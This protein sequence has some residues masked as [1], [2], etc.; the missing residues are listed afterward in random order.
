MSLVIEKS[1]FLSTIIYLVKIVMLTSLQTDTIN[2]SICI[3]TDNPIGQNLGR[4]QL[5]G[6]P[7]KICRANIPHGI[8]FA[9]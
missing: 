4:S 5:C 9:I 7:T 6:T 1:F 8:L 3:D 2:L